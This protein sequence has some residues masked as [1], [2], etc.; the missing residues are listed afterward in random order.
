MKKH[1]LQKTRMPGVFAG[2]ALGAAMAAAI[3]PGSVGAAAFTNGTWGG[4]ASGNWSDVGNWVGSVPGGATS[5]VSLTFNISLADRTVTIDGISRTVGVLNIGDP[6]ITYKSYT[7]A[8]SGG[9]SL[10]LDNGAASAQINKLVATSAVADT[11]SAPLLLNSNLV[12]SNNAPASLFITGEVTANTT[13]TKTISNQG[14]GNYKVEMSGEIGDGAGRVA[15][16]QNSATS[17]LVLSGANTYSGDTTISTGTLL[18]SNALALQNSTLNYINGTGTVLFGNGLTAYTLGGL[19][20]N[21]NLALT[22]TAGT[23]MALTIGN[24]H[25]ITTYSGVLSAGGS[26]IKSGSGLLALTGANSYTG[27]TLVTAGTLTVNGALSA[28]STVTVASGAILSGTGTA[29]GRVTISAGGHLA[30]GNSLGTLNTGALILSGTY[31]AEVGAAGV[32]DK[33]TVTGTLNLNGATLNL[34]N[35]GMDVGAH[36]IIANSG[37]RTGQFT[38]VINTNSNLLHEK[39][40]YSAN[41]VDLNLYRLAAPGDL[42]AAITFGDALVGASTA[43][44][45]GIQNTT[46]TDGYS[47]SLNAAAGVVSGF[48]FTTSAVSGL[49]AGG[50][51]NLTLALD[52]S[53]AGA[54][55]GGAVVTFHSNGAGSSDY[56]LTLIGTQTV[57]LAGSVYAAADLTLNTTNTLDDG[58]R[59]SIRNAAGFRSLAQISATNTAGANGWAFNGLTNSATIAAGVTNTSGYVTAP[60][61]SGLLNGT[62][63]SGTLGLTFQNNQ[64]LLGASANDLGPQTWTLSHRVSGN[65][66]PTGSAQTAVVTAGQSLAG[67]NAVTGTSGGALGT[68]VTF[69]AGTSTG[70]TASMTFRTRIGDE[71]TSLLSDVVDLNSVTGTSAFVLQMSYNPADLGTLPEGTLYL[72]WKDGLVFVNAGDTAAYGVP[73]IGAWGGTLDVGEW[74]VDPVAHTAWAVI[75][76]NS[77]FAVVP[78]PATIVLFGLGGL[79]L[80]RRRRIAS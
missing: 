36:Q 7:L 44:S 63:Q 79:A 24:N 9:A 20:G 43:K 34:L 57:S 28:S 18:V 8:A 25:Q 80:L 27:A 14:T 37:S 73:V 72:G 46:S 22:N 31:D 10:I 58:G 6:G 5:T 45:L 11:I 75:A 49:A 38:T 42:S 74:G 55:S 33:V 17:A 48:T 59:L 12:L 77:E 60:S 13:G 64:G 16:T 78:E 68:S 1:D 54:K 19:T 23:A 51:Q 52:T 26:L 40:A 71:I 41:S 39:M 65:L 56:G 76:H 66:A 67:F 2:M 47:E 70:G 53:A 3:A 62:V 29:A 4:N 30:P 35:S 50:S 61:A 32:A 69:L 21:K 15:V